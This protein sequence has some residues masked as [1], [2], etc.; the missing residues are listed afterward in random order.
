MI[1]VPLFDLKFLPES[2]ADALGTSNRRPWTASD[3]GG[4]AGVVFCGTGDAIGRD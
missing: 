2:A 1:P 3:A 4:N